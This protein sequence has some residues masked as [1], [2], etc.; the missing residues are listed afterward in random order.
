[1]P[2][3][4]NTPGNTG[5]RDGVIKWLLRRDPCQKSCSQVSLLETRF[6][7]NTMQHCSR[8][9]SYFFLFKEL[10][11]ARDVIFCVIVT[12]AKAMS[13]KSFICRAGKVS[14]NCSSGSSLM[15]RSLL[16]SC[17]QHVF[18]HHGGTRVK[19]PKSRAKPHN[20][21]TLGAYSLFYLLW[22]KPHS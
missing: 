18:S 3:T 20:V 17:A 10:R 5:A 11:V 2:L 15:A 12:I 19:Q 16:A 6:A 8:K 13:S 9:V 22:H 1:M 14:H 7:Q 21:F 4:Y